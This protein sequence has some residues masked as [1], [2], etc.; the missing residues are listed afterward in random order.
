MK[1][2]EYTEV[3]DDLLTLLEG[4]SGASASYWQENPKYLKAVRFWEQNTG[5]TR[6][7]VDRVSWTDGKKI[8]KFRERN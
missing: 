7:E 5:K 6:L 1:E 4:E 3:I 2:S 8:L